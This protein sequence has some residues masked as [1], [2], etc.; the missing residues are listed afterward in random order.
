MC[1]HVAWR[2]AQHRDCDEV[3]LLALAD[4]FWSK[5]S[6]E[7]NSGCWLWA[8]NSNGKGYGVID[9][10]QRRNKTGKVYLAHRDSLMLHGVEDPGEAVLHHCDNPACVN[11][12]H[13]SAGTHVENARD[14]I[15]KGRHA[16]AWKP[17]ATHCPRGHELEGNVYEYPTGERSCAT[18]K[19]EAHKRW[20]SAN[21]ER[22]RTLKREGARRR[23][24]RAA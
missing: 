11:P 12:S 20:V 5:V 23:R 15:L 1:V 13:L 24:K 9:M 10:R 19:K 6:P 4:R 14:T 7:P 21:Q 22:Y 8:G 16:R 17:G 3:A 2:A 18:C